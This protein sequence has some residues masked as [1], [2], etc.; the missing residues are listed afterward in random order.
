MNDF[1]VFAT[2]AEAAKSFPWLWAGIT[3]LLGLATVISTGLALH[4]AKTTEAWRSTAEAWKSELEARDKRL[5]R[6]EDELRVTNERASSAEQTVK[7]L[8]ASHVGPEIGDTIIKRIE[9]LTEVQREAQRDL[10]EEISR[11]QRR[12]NG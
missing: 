2:S 1:L 7:I 3:C 11:I 10:I 6:L 9:E 12:N 5:D 8:I 4:K